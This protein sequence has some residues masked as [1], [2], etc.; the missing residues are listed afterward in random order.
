[1]PG[2]VAHGVRIDLGRAQAVEE[3]LR[4]CVREQADR[5]GV[6]GV[7]DRVRARRLDDLGQAARDLLDGLLPGARL[8]EA[9]A[10][11]PDPP[12]RP[13]QARLGIEPGAVVADRALRAERAAAH[14]VV[15]VAAHDDVAVAPQHED[16]ARVV[17]VARAD[18]ADGIR[19]DSRH[20]RQSRASAIE[21]EHG[22]ERPVDL[23][24]IAEAHETVGLTEPALVHGPQLVGEDP[25]RHT[26]ELDRRPERR[27]TCLP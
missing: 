8:E 25:R 12:Q 18:G 3:A 9:L 23:L 24:Q 13:G 27:R 15:R 26:I 16:P 14:V 10:L 19:E 21:A 1:M 22:E 7:E 20:A 5:A 6:V 2:L 17:A 11:R 4:R